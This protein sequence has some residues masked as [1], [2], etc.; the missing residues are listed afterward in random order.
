MGKNFASGL[1]AGPT[2]AVI[3]T[4]ICLLVGLEARTT[5]L[6]A[7]VFLVVGT[8]GTTIIAAVISRSKEAVQ[9]S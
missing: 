8:I 9:R 4:S 7:L 6:W 3:W 1:T 5:G 2:A